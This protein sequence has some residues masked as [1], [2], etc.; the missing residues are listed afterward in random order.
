MSTP[1]RVLVVDD[2]S[3]MRSMLSRMI[4]RDA[5]FHVVGKAENG[6][7]G[8][9]L[10]KELNPDVITMDIEMPVMTGIEA[11]EHIMRDCPT[12]VVMV[13]TLTEKGAAVTVKALEIGAVDFLPKALQESGSNV[14]QSGDKL[15]EKLAHAASAKQSMGGA[16]TADNAGASQ[17]AASAPVAP[18]LNASAR[19]GQYKVV[20]IGSSTG[21]PKALQQ[22][23]SALPAQVNV[24][25]VIAQHMPE[26]FT[27][28]LAARLNETSPLTVVEAIDGMGLQPGHAYIAPGGMHTR[29]GHGRLHVAPLNGESHYKPSVDVL[30]ESAVQTFGKDTLAIML[31]GMGDD[32]KNSFLKIKNL[33]GYVIAQDQATSVVHGMPGALVAAGGATEVLPLPDIAPA[34]AK[35]LGIA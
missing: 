33:G 7:E 12:P 1:I 32:G 4:E 18:T 9:R 13:S 35:L 3:F 5:R 17:P 6:Q 24:P 15:H 26:H 34:I 14:F 29:V 10:A 20:I 25:I 8:V 28:A 30:G 19:P 21:G 23:L 27:G 2:S 11:L 31:T 22:V 16:S